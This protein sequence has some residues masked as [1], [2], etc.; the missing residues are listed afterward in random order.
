MKKMIV[1]VFALFSFGVLSAQET[2]EP[3]KIE[4]RTSFFVELGG[5]GILF[6]SNIDHRFRKSRLGPGGR[7]GVG[8]VTSTEEVGTPGTYMYR[9]VSVVT[10]PV[11]LN[12]IF[13]KNVSPHTFE[14]GA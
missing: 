14:V 13:G 1:F 8:F 3:G 2:A 9:N 6:S 7:V 11:Q 5:P 10:I 4:G 12:Y